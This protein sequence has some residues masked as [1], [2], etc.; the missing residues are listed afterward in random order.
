MSTEDKYKDKHFSK[1]TMD[2]LEKLEKSK[3]E[4]NEQ[5]RRESELVSD[6]IVDVEVLC[7]LG[8]PYQE[9]FEKLS[10]HVY[11]TGGPLLT[12]EVLR[13]YEALEDRIRKI[14]RKDELS[15]IEE[16]RRIRRLYRTPASW[17]VRMAEYN[18]KYN[19][20]SKDSAVEPV[21]PRK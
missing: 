9:Y 20:E 18:E 15:P 8:A 1:E 14:E 10:K 11:Q 5:I 17:E 16:E 4:F 13:K 2:L 3:E 7:M 12:P 6:A 19:P 21:K